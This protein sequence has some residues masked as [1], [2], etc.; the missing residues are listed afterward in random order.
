MKKRWCSIALTAAMVVSMAAGS[1]LTV[2]AE[3]EITLRVFSNLPDRKNGQ[4]LVEQMLI[5]EY[6]EANPNVKIEVEAL[7]EEAYLSL[8]HI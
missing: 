2:N 3:E 5:D 7:D 6:M 8:I 1:A 4:G